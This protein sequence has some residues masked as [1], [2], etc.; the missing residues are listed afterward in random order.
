MVTS[1]TQGV[2]ISVETF[3]Q[4]D[5][6]HA[7]KEEFVFAYRITIEN[8]SDLTIKL[9]RRHWHIYDTAALWREVEGEGVVGEQPVIAPGGMHQYISGCHL[10]SP[11]GKMY[12]I[13]LMERQEDMVLFEVNIPEFIMLTSFILN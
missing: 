7:V 11:I 2:K 13:Y 12:G 3:Y 6:S 1:T 10:Q 5:F 9:L 8:T 4:P